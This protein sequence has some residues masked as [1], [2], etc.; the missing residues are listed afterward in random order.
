M[1][2]KTAGDE[3]PPYDISIKFV[4][5]PS[6]AVGECLGAPAEKRYR[7]CKHPPIIRRG[8][9]TREPPKLAL[10]VSGNPYPRR[11]TKND[12]VYANKNGGRRLTAEGGL[13]ICYRQE[14]RLMI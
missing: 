9:R 4:Q 11:P 12:I 3:P 13:Y 5:T 1:Q 8:R 10:L 6:R 7:L 14:C 2:T